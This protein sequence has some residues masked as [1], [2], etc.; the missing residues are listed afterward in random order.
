M[1]KRQRRGESKA[2]KIIGFS[3]DEADCMGMSLC[4]Y[5]Q[6][7][8]LSVFHHLFSGLAPSALSVLCPSQVSAGHTRST[9]NTLLLKFIKIQDHS[10]P[11][12]T[13]YSFF[14]TYGI[15]LHILFN[16]ILPSSSSRQL[17]TTISDHPQSRTMIFS[18]LVRKFFGNRQV[19]VRVSVITDYSTYCT[20][21]QNVE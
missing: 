14:T 9:I 19:G 15:N 5:R 16:L 12:L 11:P 1:Q 4:H 10:S 8:G 17:F 18:T 13:C 2:F 20:H 21:P 7:G 3:G 6:V